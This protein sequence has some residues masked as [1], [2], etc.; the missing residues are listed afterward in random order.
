MFDHFAGAVFDRQPCFGLGAAAN[1]QALGNGG[2]AMGCAGK[3]DSD[4]KV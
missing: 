3:R 2:H 1:G 4:R